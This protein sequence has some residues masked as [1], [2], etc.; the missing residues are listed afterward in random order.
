MEKE[1]IAETVISFLD[2]RYPGSGAL[3]EMFDV[4]TPMTWVHY[5][6]NWKGSYLGWQITEKTMPP[7]RMSKKLPW[8]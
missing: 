1:K 3:V 4:S 8:A 2:K 6:G 5:T 7:F